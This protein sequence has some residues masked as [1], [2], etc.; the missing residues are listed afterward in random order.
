MDPKKGQFEYL[1]IHSLDCLYN[2]TVMGETV[3]GVCK[4]TKKRPV[5]RCNVSVKIWEE[6]LNP[7]TSGT[8]LHRSAT[9]QKWKE[10]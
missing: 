1:D 9:L 10:E 5:E 6:E 8:I 4:N 3:Y 2:M 7:N